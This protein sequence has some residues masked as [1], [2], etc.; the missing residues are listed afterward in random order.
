MKKILVGIVIL[1]I[2]FLSSCQKE[3]IGKSNQTIE[4][5]LKFDT[6]D[7]FNQYYKEL[8]QF[9]TKEELTNWAEN[10]NYN[11]Y[12]R[13][14]TEDNELPYSDIFKT[15]INWN[16][17]FEIG[18]N[19]IWLNEG[20]MYAIPKSQ[21]NE[22]EQLKL[23]PNQLEAIGDIVP[24]QENNS[25]RTTRFC[26]GKR[27]SRHQREF[28]QYSYQPC[29]GSFSNTT[30]KR[31]Y[32]HEV[33]NESFSFYGARYSNL[34]LKVKLEY[35]YRNRKW[36]SAGEHRK[37]DINVYGDFQVVGETHFFNINGSF[38]CSRDVTALIVSHPP[39]YSASYYCFDLYM[40]GAITQQI[41]GD[42]Y[43][44]RWTSSGSFSN[45]LW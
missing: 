8:S 13:Y 1:T 26:A 35:R 2:F 39:Y 20:I 5:R 19:I 10:K 45:P 3:D 18:E 12:L 11:S 37:I 15:L 41:K 28:H 30:G 27:D 16:K 44:N 43:I 25:N 36:K 23:N 21:E 14:E 40:A 4:S 9:Y 33:L 38:D 42:S 7:Q 6:A 24:I 29:G 31:K 22:I 17:E 34:Y 32:V